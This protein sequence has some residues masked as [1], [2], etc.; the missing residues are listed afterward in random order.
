MS[1]ILTAPSRAKHEAA[2]TNVVLQ[3]ASSMSGHLLVMGSSA[4]EQK[5]GEHYV[6]SNN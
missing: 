2:R 6:F 4:S 1:A 3:D 5:G